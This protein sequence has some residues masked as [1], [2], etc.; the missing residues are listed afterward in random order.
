MKGSCAC[1]IVHFSQLSGLARFD[2]ITKRRASPFNEPARLHQSRPACLPGWLTSYVQRSLHL[3]VNREGVCLTSCSNLIATD[4]LCEID[5]GSQLARLLSQPV[6][7]ASSPNII[8]LDDRC[9]YVSQ[10]K[11]PVSHKK[12]NILWIVNESSDSCSSSVNFGDGCS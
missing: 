2:A 12:A 1:S 10:H 9:K 3:K 8:R 4:I 7:R 11:Y 5:H 6:C